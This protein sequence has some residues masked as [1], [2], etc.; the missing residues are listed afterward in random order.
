MIWRAIDLETWLIAPASLAP[1]PVSIAWA[2]VQS[3][4]SVTLRLWSDPCV[5]AELGEV[6]AGGLI[7][8]N[9]A[10]DMAVLAHWYPS[11]R[12]AIWLAYSEGRI[13][14]TMIACRLSDVANDDV[15]K[16]YHLA[17]CCKRL[18][19][20]DVEGKH[21]PDAWRLRYRELNDTPVE[22]WPH[23][24]VQ[25]ARLD[26]TYTAMLWNKVGR[27]PTDDFECR[28]A[29]ALHLSSA[30]GLRCDKMAVEALEISLRQ[31][32]SERDRV[33]REHGVLRAN[34][35]KDNKAVEDL[36]LAELGQDAPKTA[37]GRVKIDAET[38]HLCRHPALVALAD[39]AAASKLQS[40]FL[41][42]VK[43]GVG[44][45]IHPRYVSVLRSDRVSAQDP[46]IQQLPRKGGVRETFVPRQGNVFVSVDYAGAEL[47]CLAQVLLVLFDESMMADSIRKGYDLHLTT[48]SMLLGRSYEQTVAD[49][50]AG[51]NAAVE[52]RQ[53][54]KALN[55]G[56]P[57]GLAAP[58]LQRYLLGY[59][60]EVTLTQATDYRNRWLQLYPEMER[61]FK[62]LKTAARGGSFRIVHP[63]TKFVRGGCEYTSGA[64]HYFQSLL[65]KVAKEALWQV[66]VECYGALGKRTPLLGT[67]IAAFIHDEILLE[68][69]EETAPEAA[70]RL[71]EIMRAASKVWMPDLP[72]GSDPTLMSCWSKKAKTLRDDKGRL[73]V[74]NP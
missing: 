66:S 6:L 67:R 57:G 22:Q 70:E 24:A 60:I 1:R 31:T 46:N 48:A 20:V 16:T 50:K 4:E 63:L 33:L 72:L 37:T 74:W 51:E 44:A 9:I 62:M 43:K 3:P 59:G 21:G 17:D 27:Q 52:A 2:D 55:F 64:N 28:A 35:T 49:Y 5:L 54:A 40:A 41:P 11:L 56:I 32:V 29:W 47:V 10:F 13:L 45:P 68:A 61:Y 39:A 23:A 69:K 19:G 15:Q 18:L 71:A 14:D 8:H 36:V 26:V 53:L 65:A 30:W 38:L 7:G 25:Y 42:V 58:T 12:E 73:R 34:G